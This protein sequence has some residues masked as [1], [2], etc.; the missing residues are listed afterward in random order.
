MAKALITRPA[1]RRDSTSARPQLKAKQ[2]APACDANAAPT[3]LFGFSSNRYACMTII[4]HQYPGQVRQLTP[5]HESEER[6]QSQTMH[7][8]RY[9]NQLKLQLLPISGR[10]ICLKVARSA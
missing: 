2:A 8:P 3:A 7:S 6:H 5:D 1:S 4:D 9:P 10:G